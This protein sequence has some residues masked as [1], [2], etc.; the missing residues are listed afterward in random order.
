MM[1]YHYKQL[2][3]GR[4]GIFINNSLVASIGCVD[5]CQQIMQFLEN[6]VSEQDISKLRNNH[7]VNPYFQELKL[8]P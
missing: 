3:N 8:R 4:W 2:P 1:L 5:T 6:R 7:I